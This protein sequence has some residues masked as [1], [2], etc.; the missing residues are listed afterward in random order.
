MNWFEDALRRLPEP[1]AGARE[2]VGKA[3]LGAD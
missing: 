3:E 1:D 2:P